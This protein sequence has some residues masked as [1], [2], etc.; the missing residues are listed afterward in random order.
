MFNLDKWF[1]I[2]GNFTFDSVD[3]TATVYK[4]V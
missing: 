3:A 2:S 1:Y 4:F